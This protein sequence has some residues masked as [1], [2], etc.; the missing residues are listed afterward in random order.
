MGCIRQPSSKAEATVLKAD[1]KCPFCSPSQSTGNVEEMEHCVLSC[2]LQ[3][4]QF[5]IDSA[6]QFLKASDFS[7]PAAGLL[8]GVIVQFQADGKD[9]DL[10]TI[11]GYL[12]DKNMV[13]SIGG[14]AF[15]SDVYTKAPNPAHIKNYAQ[16]VLNASKRRQL[17]Q[18]AQKIAAHAQ[19]TPET[20][21]GD[22]RDEILPLM[23][24]ADGALMD[25]AVDEIRPLKAVAGKYLDFIDK[26]AGTIDPPVSTGIRK[27][28]AMLN[29][30]IRREYIIIGGRQGHGKT[31]LSMQLAGH[32]ANA[33]RRGYV[34][35][36]EM[37]DL[38]ILMRDIAREARIP[39]SHV[40]GREEFCGNEAPKTSKMIMKMMADWDIHYTDSPYITLDSVAAHARTLHR[41]KPL[42]FIVID[43]LQ[44]IPRKGGKTARD[45]QMITEL[46][47]QISCLQKELKCTV[48]APVQL[49]DDGLIRD[50]RAILDAP[51]CFIRIEMTTDENDL[52]ESVVSNSGRLRVLKNRF[53]VSDRSCPVLRNGEFQCFED[54]D[55]D[56]PA[57]KHRNPR[58]RI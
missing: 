42:D 53:G 55:E 25:G 31:L 41:V 10:I 2:M 13:D 12:Y 9:V 56:P 8:F 47:K 22:W 4:P 48:I 19:G 50:A 33:G 52:G 18:I 46:S 20:E 38:Q 14:P 29:G 21:S 37:A 35:G 49:N 6:L 17:F 54:R 28:D 44:L 40:M 11:T 45:D 3:S 58:S 1:M 7:S 39:V 15:V 30:G 27:L 32:L 24:Q 26:G 57:P 43:Y 23:R 5:A 36:Y 51:Q 16:K 34:V